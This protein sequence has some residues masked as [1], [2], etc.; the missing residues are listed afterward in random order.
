MSDEGLVVRPGSTM[1][2]REESCPT[3]DI[4]IFNFKRLSDRYTLGKDPRAQYAFK[5]QVLGVSCNSHRLS[6]LAAFFIDL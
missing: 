3:K 4:H 5:C 1:T 2:T 6:Q